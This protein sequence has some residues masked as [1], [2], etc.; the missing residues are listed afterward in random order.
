MTILLQNHASFAG[1][2]VGNGSVTLGGWMERAGIRR[3]EQQLE[4]RQAFELQSFGQ[5][6]GCNVKVPRHESVVGRAEPAL[7]RRIGLKVSWV[8]GLPR[9]VDFARQ[10][11]FVCGI[12]AVGR[13][14]G[15]NAAID[16]GTPV[17]LHERPI[18]RIS[19]VPHGAM[20]FIGD[21]GTFAHFL[22]AQA[23]V[24]DDF[25]TAA[26]VLARFAAITG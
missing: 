18:V 10:T 9:S 3:S 13:R 25:K 19:R 11:Q 23:E 12:R 16:K 4:P 24:R 21:P 2:R 22:F 14:A 26:A 1:N 7:A 20:K 5:Q 15:T 6:R 17:R 8:V